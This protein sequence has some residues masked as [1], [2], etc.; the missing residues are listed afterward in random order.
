LGRKAILIA[1]PTASGKS[2]LAIERAEA[3][4]GIVVNAD[5]M[6]VYDVLNVLTARPTADDLARVE[7]RLY[8]F[9]PPSVRCSVGRW[10]AGVAAL[11]GDPALKDRTF[12]FAGGTGLYFEALENGIAEI[13][14]VP[15][16]AVAEAEALVRPLD[17]DGRRALLLARDPGMAA[18]LREPDPQRLVRALSVRIATGRSL[19][20]WQREMSPPLLF[21][22]EVERVVLDVDRD[23]LAQRIDGRF[24]QMI[25][26]GAL[27]EVEALTA[28]GLDGDL[29][30]MKA[31]G[32]RE[33]TAWQNGDMSREDAVVHAVT[34]TRQYAKRQR[35]WFRQR[36][37]HWPRLSR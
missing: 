32:V 7:H 19:L 3:S 4:A 14:D 27:A 35:T 2:A 9:V 37:A 33:I 10:L 12:I 13:P 20:E 6:Q 15:A 31:I 17:R 24:R 29:P 1:G 36:M 18:V 26:E 22:A 8:G 5:S 25:E 34:A 16:S 21:G 30:A 23:T 11:F 28:L